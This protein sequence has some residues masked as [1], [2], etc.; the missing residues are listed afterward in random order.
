MAKESAPRTRL[1][2]SHWTP[3]LFVAPVAAYLLLFQG[4]PL[5]QEFVLSFTSTSLLS[6]T[7]HTFVG[8]QN[9]VDLIGTDDFLHS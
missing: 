9:Y 6:P 1:E 7:V 5:V 8:G 2:G 3:Y 4:Y